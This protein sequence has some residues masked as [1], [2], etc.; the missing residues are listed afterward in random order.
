MKKLMVL[1]FALLASNAYADLD[2]L[3]RAEM[4]QQRQEQAAAQKARAAAAERDRI[5]REEMA[6]EKARREAKEER[7]YQERMAD[8]YRDQKYEDLKRELEIAELQEKL[9]AK[10]GSR[11]YEDRMRELELK[12]RE[13]DRSYE[14]RM[15]ELQ[16]REAEAMSSARTKKADKFAKESLKDLHAKRDSVYAQNDVI[17]SEKEINKGMG[18]MLGNSK[19][20]DD[21]YLVNEQGVESIETRGKVSIAKIISFTLIFLALIAGGLFYFLSYQKNNKNS[22]NTPQ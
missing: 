13:G 20:N 3:R 19:L 11:S 6:K 14:E 12:E 17:R 10:K 2:S 5:R 9:E 7:D 16:L 8:K 22:P 21:V 18:K 4:Q 1:C 15:H